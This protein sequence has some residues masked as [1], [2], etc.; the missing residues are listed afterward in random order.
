MKRIGWPSL[1][2]AALFV[3]GL[4]LALFE[5]APRSPAP[6]EEEGVNVLRTGEMAR[7]GEQIDARRVVVLDRL[8]A[9]DRVTDALLRGELSFE[10][11]VERFRQLTEIDPAAVAAMRAQYGV[12]GEEM[13]F[14]NVLVFVR[15]AAHYQPDRAK[16]VLPR[17]EA[18]MSHRFPPA[19][20]AEVPVR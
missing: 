11:A 12:A 13:Y 18:E 1:A 14:R 15:R 3:A 19:A 5:T 17:L 7:R 20:A 2:L 8:R 4:V 16:V 9:K 10:Q 6:W